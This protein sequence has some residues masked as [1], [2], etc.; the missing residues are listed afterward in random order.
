MKEF[1]ANAEIVLPATSINPRVQINSLRVQTMETCELAAR[2]SHMSAPCRTLDESEEFVARWGVRA[3]HS[4]ILEHAY[5]SV[6]LKCNRGVSHEMVRHR[7]GISIIQKS[8]RYVD[9]TRKKHGDGSIEMSALPDLDDDMRELYEC[10]MAQC[11]ATYRVLRDDGV[12]AEWARN[13]LPN[14]LETELFIT[15]NLREWRHIFK[16]RCSKHAHPEMR[17]VMIPLLRQFLHIWP[18]LFWDVGMQIAG[19]PDVMSVNDMHGALVPLSEL[20]VPKWVDLSDPISEW[21]PYPD[22]SE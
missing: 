6:R 12:P 8:T 7:I 18:R 21:Q 9:Y 20:E 11:E 13:V 1:I 15:A 10:T 14:A 19:A 16:L 2:T 22:V 17:A 5:V 3:G 4:S